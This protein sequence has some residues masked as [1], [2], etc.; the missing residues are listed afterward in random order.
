MLLPSRSPSRRF[1]Y[2]HVATYDVGKY[3]N[4]LPQMK[5]LRKMWSSK[6]KKNLQLA[7]MLRFGVVVWQPS[8]ADEWLQQKAALLLHGVVAGFAVGTLVAQHGGGPVHS[9]DQALTPLLPTSFH[10]CKN[11]SAMPATGSPLL[12]TS[13]RFSCMCQCLSTCPGATVKTLFQIRTVYGGPGRSS[14]FKQ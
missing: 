12:S 6:K 2:R 3:F 14:A 11:L 10:Q 9:H 8:F 5:N 1:I 13:G 7:S 4:L